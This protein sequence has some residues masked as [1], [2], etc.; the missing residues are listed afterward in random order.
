MIRQLS[1]RLK[2]RIGL[3]AMAFSVVLLFAAAMYGLYAYRGLV[4]SLAA[5]SAELPVADQLSQHV[6][7]L[8]VIIAQARERHAVVQDNGLQIPSL[9]VPASID[10]NTATWSL[11]DMRQHYKAEWDHFRV[12][13]ERY[14][15]RLEASSQHLDTNFSN[16]AAER[17]TLDT[18]DRIVARIDANQHYENWWTDD[19]ASLEDEIDTLRELVSDLPSHLHRRLNQVSG[20]VADRYRVAITLACVTCFSS[21]SLLIWGIQFFRRTVSRPLDQLVRES[22]I[23]AGGKF[24]HRI[25]SIANDEIGELACAMN[26][27]TTRFRDIRD[28]LDRQV[29]ERTREVVRSEQL[30]S[31][32]F[33]AAGVAHEI[34]NPLHSIALC[35]ESLE[36]RLKELVESERQN[37]PDW[38][39]VASYLEMIQ[40]EAFRCKQITEKLLDFSRM[41]DSQ[42][43]PSELRELVATV[44]EMVQHLG[45]YNGR[46]LELV[47]G[48][49]V[50]AEVNAQEIKQVVLNLITN[51]LD[52]LEENGV[53]EVRVFKDNGVAKIEVTD[54]GCG[55]N[56]EVIEH[57]FE[58]F[59]TRRRD[60]QGTGLG[61]SI[62][63]RIVEEHGGKLVAVSEGEG[64][65]SKFIVELP[66]RVAAIGRRAA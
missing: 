21:V 38:E 46:R 7:N 20:D 48:E 40:R 30:A 36:G 47:A 54:N 6:G 44:I 11:R 2:L 5:R 41:G 63:F 10:D 61:L 18:I 25:S 1:I 58:P 8:R 53:V 39:I 60:G 14:R 33:L 34:N 17:K 56:D 29:R 50:V 9:V 35:S 23:I 27:M 3:G 26:D 16:D 52:S 13:L 66:P 59:F 57:L 24:D 4:K 43:H 31:V 55:L 51:G 37:N 45:R 22:R 15:Q 65:G 32:G 64:K 62:S 19:P 12:T 42:R 49:P 28:D